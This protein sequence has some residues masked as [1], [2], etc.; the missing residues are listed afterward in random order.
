MVVAPHPLRA[1][2]ASRVSFASTNG[3]QRP[4]GL[5]AVTT[6]SIR[7][8]IMKTDGLPLQ[9]VRSSVLRQM[10]CG[11][12]CPGA[13]A[14]CGDEPATGAFVLGM[15]PETD[16]TLRSWSPIQH[17]TYMEKSAPELRPTV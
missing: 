9:L 3:I 15:H 5:L 7:P 12:S 2:H 13:G 11:F 10:F 1:T 16:A 4:I 17:P 8:C 14:A 6:P